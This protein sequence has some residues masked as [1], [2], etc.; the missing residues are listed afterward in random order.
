MNKENIDQ[1]LID[2]DR[3]ELNDLKPFTRGKSL[4]HKL[5]LHN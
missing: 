5:S 4:Y 3:A 1:M 2:F